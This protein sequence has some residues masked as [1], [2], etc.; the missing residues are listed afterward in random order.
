VPDTT[1]EHVLANRASWDAE[2]NQWVESGRQDWESEDPNW[3]MW[4]VPEEELRLLPED[5]NGRDTIEL[6]CGTGY[7]SA[8]LARRGARPT[9]LDNSSR[10]LATAAMLQGEFR[11]RFPL[12]HADAERLPFPDER[13]DFAVSE[14][15]AALWCDPYRWIP[16]AHRMLRPGG[17]LMFLTNSPLVTM[18]APELEADGPATDR[19]L[20]PYFGM[21][22]VEW[23]DEDGAV[24]FHLPH[25]EMVR[26]L[27]DTGFEIEDLVE[28]Q[29]PE[30][31]E[32][33]FPWVTSEWASK[34]P[35]EEVWK[36]RKVWG[37]DR[38][39]TRRS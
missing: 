37:F 15:G 39:V 26:L 14:Y 13:F 2:A 17:R 12:V 5:L 16:E 6:G 24:E 22:R 23:P 9:G 11:I 1:Q 35:A 30:G 34:C 3:G 8:W 20:R 27:R 38:Y 4:R 36:A 31:V 19:L 32:T 21:F 25:G 18:F 10:K 33:H 29:V 28:I 7:V